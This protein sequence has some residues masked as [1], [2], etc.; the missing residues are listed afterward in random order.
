MST[1]L[2]ALHK[3]AQTSE[4]NFETVLRSHYPRADRWTFYRAEESHRTGTAD[5]W[6]SQMATNAAIIAAHDTYIADLH[7]YYEARDGSAGFLGSRG[8]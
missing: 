8:A 2:S 3:T 7:R 6:D 1:K 5:A 4:S